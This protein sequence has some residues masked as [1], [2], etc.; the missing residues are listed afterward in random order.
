MINTIKHLAYAL[1]CSEHEIIYVASHS[2]EYYYHLR[3]PK[4]KYGEDQINPD[5]TPR[6]RELYPSKKSLKKI[7]ERIAVQLQKI[8][9]ADY[10]YGSE[11]GKSN[12]DN[13][14]THIYG[15]YFLNID[16]RNFF[17]GITH[18]QVFHMLRGYKFSPT[19]ARLLTQLT[20]YHGSLSQGA[21]S[22]PIIANLVFMQT[23]DR[24]NT[25]ATEHNL[26]FTTYLDDLI[27]SS[28]FD[29]KGLL[30]SILTT[31]KSGRFHLNHRKISYRI[32]KPEVTGIFIQNER[33]FVNDILKK[34]ASKKNLTKRYI[35]RIETANRALDSLYNKSL[36]KKPW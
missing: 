10:Q 3:K 14:L 16:L 17:S 7:Q 8:P 9:L 30:P 27:F 29:F 18:H 23:G 11:K 24:L 22:S 31:V 21:P 36:A 2:N 12:I 15:K 5:G 13:A 33:M 6:H 35:D 1:R 32:Y 26:T 25:I 4:K 19:V 34:N 20:T 28:K